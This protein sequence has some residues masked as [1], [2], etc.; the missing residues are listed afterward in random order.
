MVRARKQINDKQNRMWNR[1]LTTRNIK[2]YTETRR[3]N[4]KR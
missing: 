2:N 1:V 3:F 4:T